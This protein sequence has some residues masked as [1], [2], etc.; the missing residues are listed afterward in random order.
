VSLY[1]KYRAKL[2][3]DVLTQGHVTETLQAAIKNQSFGHAYVFVGTRGTGK[4]SIARIFARTVN[5]S[6]EE[7]VK[8]HGEPCNEC[9]SCVLSLNGSN[10]DIIE[11]DAASNRGIDEVR[12]L[13]EGVD[14]LPSIGKYKIYIVDEA[15]M[16]T[17]EAFNALLKTIEEPPKHVVFIMCTTEIFKLPATILSRS[18]VFELKHASIEQ[19]IAKIDYILK[20]EGYQIAQEGKEVIAKLGKGSFRDTESILEKIIGS[21]FEGEVSLEQVISTLGLSSL[22]QIEKSKTLI[23]AKDLNNLMLFI[24]NEVDEGMISNFNHQLA[25]SVYE[26]IAK[27][28]GAGNVDSFKF[29]VFDFLTSLD[30]DLRNSVNPK[31][32]YIA[33]ILNFLKNF[34][35]SA[36]YQMINVNSSIDQLQSNG[37]NNNMNMGGQSVQQSETIEPPKDISRN[38]SALLRYRKS[39]EQPQVPQQSQSSSTGTEEVKQKFISKLDFLDFIKASNSFLF[40][41]FSHHEFQILTSSIVVEVEKQME[42]DLLMKPQSLALIKSFGDKHGLELKLEF[43]EVKVDKRTKEEKVVMEIQKKVEDLNDDEIKKIFNV[44]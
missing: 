3:K 34:K 33:H 39:Q 17:K 38:P 32:V 27:D 35:V 26:D 20:S 10:I 8:T 19:I 21:P 7:H 15:H 14:F 31:M 13:K 25:E 5:C 44:S 40:R 6:N 22:L 43:G 36:N 29:E 30:K 28:L 42:K 18:Q 11:M 4:T 12:D 9:D 37:I 23:Y 2:F 24:Q 16:M 41:F 1:Q